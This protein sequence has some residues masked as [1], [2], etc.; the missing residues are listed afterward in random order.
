MYPEFN[1]LVFNIAEGYLK[2]MLN[3]LE[4][5]QPFNNKEMFLAIKHHFEG[6]SLNR[7]EQKNTKS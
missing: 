7:K 1:S 3:T 5:N 6:N 2:T 4:N